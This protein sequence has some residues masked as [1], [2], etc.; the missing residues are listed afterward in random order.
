MADSELLSKLNRRQQLIEENAND[1]EKPVEN[2]TMDDET[3]NETDNASEEL[4]NALNQRRNGSETNSTKIQPVKSVYAEFPEFTRKQIKN[5][6]EMFKKFDENK[7]KFICLDELKRAMEKLEAPQTHLSLKAMI[8]EIDEDGDGKIN[9]REFLIL[10]RKASNGEI[11]QDS[12][13]NIF[14]QA[15]EIDVTKEGV[16]G[17]KMFFDEKVKQL[18]KSNAFEAEIK[19]EQEEKR[20][21]AEEKRLR[22]EEFTSKLKTFS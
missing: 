12:A 3:K 16:A 6:E 14:A 7:D 19:N 21:A 2:R 10:F 22:R 1:D 18:T 4:K 15:S 13:L 17:A 20:R 11:A 5:Y 8:K 9:F